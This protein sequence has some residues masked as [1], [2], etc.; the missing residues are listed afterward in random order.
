LQNEETKHQEFGSVPDKLF[1]IY[2]YLHNVH[3]ELDGGGRD[4]LLPLEAQAGRAW[5]K[6]RRIRSE[7][8]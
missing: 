1:E 7:F 3:L 2:D 8:D 5:P 4:E 6:G